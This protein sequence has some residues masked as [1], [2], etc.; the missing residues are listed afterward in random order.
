MIDWPRLIRAL[1]GTPEPVESVIQ[2]FICISIEDMAIILNNKLNKMGSPADIY[3][4]DVSC[5]IYRKQDVLD[6]HGLNEVSSIPYVAESHDCDDFAAEL[7]GKFAG[8][9]WTNLHALNFFIAED[10]IFYFIEPQKGLISQHLEAWQGNEIRF[11][12]AR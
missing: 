11:I 7:Y 9:V 3:L 4:P 1:Q 2:P 10:S 5:K 12:L 8:L 6:F